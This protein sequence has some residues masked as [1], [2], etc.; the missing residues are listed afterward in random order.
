[1][2]GILTKKRAKNRAQ[3]NTKRQLT[4]F[5]KV[6][7]KLGEP[8]ITMGLEINDRCTFSEK[9]EVTEHFLTSA[10]IDKR[11]HHVPTGYLPPLEPSQVQ[12]FIKSI[13]LDGLLYS[14]PILNSTR[15]GS[16]SST[17]VVLKQFFTRFTLMSILFL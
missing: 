2:W 16:G 15:W 8:P 10:F 6:L 4:E 14:K 13:C 17:I 9:T 5:V 7:C 3:E 11:D 12:A 1:M